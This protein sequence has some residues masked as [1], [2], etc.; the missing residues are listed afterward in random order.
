MVD[1]TAWDDFAF[2]PDD[3]LVVT[4]GKAGTS[5]MQAILAQLLLGIGSDAAAH[6]QEVSPW[7]DMRSSEPVA[8]RHAKLAAQTHRR[9]IKSHLALGA[10]PYS[11]YPKYIYIARDARDLLW[12]MHNH[13]SHMLQEAF[14]VLNALPDRC[15]PRLAPPPAD[16]VVYWREWMDGDGAPWWPF[17]SHTRSWWAARDRPNVLLL[18]YADMI[19][20]LPAVVRRIVAFLDIPQ[21]TPAEMATVVDRC[22]FA[23]MREH[24]SKVTPGGGRFFRGGGQSFIFKGTNGR[25]RGVLPDADVAAYEARVV[26]ELGEDCARW[27]AEGGR[28]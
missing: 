5:W 12:S 23:Y 15:G 13:H 24:A 10:L 14:D 26:A 9:F 27:L 3:V 28:V 11:P 18:H 25:W 2:R 7:L 20:D 21:L 8:D 22:S 4:Y 17:W 19:T 16:P 6:P 1:S